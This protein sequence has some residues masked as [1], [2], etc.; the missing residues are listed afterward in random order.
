MNKKI[1]LT[2]LG[3]LIASSALAIILPIVSC[4]ASAEETPP[5]VDPPV[6]TSIILTPDI[7]EL[8]NAT[9]EVTKLMKEEMESVLTYDA[10]KSIA[11]SW[12]NEE[13]LAP[14]YSDL[15]KSILKFNNEEGDLIIGVHVIE[16]ITFNSVTTLPSYDQVINGPELK[17]HLTSEYTSKDEII[18]QVGSLGTASVNLIPN[19]SGLTSAINNVTDLFATDFIKAKNRS[20]QEEILK[21]W[22]P[23]E[24]IGIDKTTAIRDRLYFT[25]N[26]VRVDSLKTIE[27]VTF[28]NELLL[29]NT[30]ENVNGPLLKVNFYHKYNLDNFFIE[31]GIIGKAL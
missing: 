12:K 27:S 7:D 21:S 20:A 1:K 8:T 24:S 28:H 5:P 4:S 19:Q 11:Q 26:G 17:V 18:I 31:V 14:K 6:D 13:L 15:I 2:L 16:K 23:G 3:S 22:K 30:G 9:N 29:P 25:F 10:K